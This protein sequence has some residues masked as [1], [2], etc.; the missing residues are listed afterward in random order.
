MFYYY[1][2][3]AY[4]TLLFL[5][6]YWGVRL[7]LRVFDAANPF[8]DQ[9]DHWKTFVPFLGYVE[10]AI[11]GAIVYYIVRVELQGMA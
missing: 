4:L 1:A 11:L 3:P 6:C 2:V 8:W 10:F 9:W 5:V 7:I